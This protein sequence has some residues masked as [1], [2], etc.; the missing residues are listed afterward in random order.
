MLSLQALESFAGE[1]CHV[2]K[3]YLNN[4]AGRKRIIAELE[5]LAQKKIPNIQFEKNLGCYFYHG[6]LN[7]CGRVGRGV[8]VGNSSSEIKETPAFGCPTVNIGSRQKSRL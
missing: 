1:G 5:R 4:D 6:C 7:I 8:C 3:T 2:L